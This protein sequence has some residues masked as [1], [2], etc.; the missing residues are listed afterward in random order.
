MPKLTAE[1]IAEVCHETN[2]VYCRL[3][4]D[5]SHRDWTT[6]PDSIKASTIAGVNTALS[7]GDKATPEL[8]HKKWSDYK[9]AEGWTLGP[10]KD[11]EKKTHPNLKP[12]QELPASERLK[13]LLF[14]RI[15]K[16][17]SV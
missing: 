16:T 5:H 9:K 12:Y 2:R 10:V 6:T 13:D 4:G 14:V 3:G 8:M 11:L 15:V 17:L 7:L 1:Q